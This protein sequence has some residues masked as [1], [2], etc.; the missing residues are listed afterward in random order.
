[1]PLM[2]VAEDLTKGIMIK[3]VGILFEP[4]T[5]A[6]QVVSLKGRKSP[7]RL[8]D[9]EGKI[10]AICGRTMVPNL[11]TLWALLDSKMKVRFGA[12][13]K[14]GY[15]TILDM[16]GESLLPLLDQA[17][18]DAAVLYW[19]YGYES[20]QRYETIC[21]PQWEFE[22][23][24]ARKNSVRTFGQVLV[25]PA[26]QLRQFS[27][28]IRT[29]LSAIQTSIDTS[30]HHGSFIAQ[31]MNVVG[32]ERR[33]FL[34]RYEEIRQPSVFLAPGEEHQVTRFLEEMVQ[35]GLQVGI[36]KDIN[37]SRLAHAV[38]RIEPSLETAKR[39]RIEAY[40]ETNFELVKESIAGII[41]ESLTSKSEEGATKGLLVYGP[42]G[43]G[44]THLFDSVVE[45]VRRQEPRLE[46]EELKEDITTARFTSA[47]KKI[48]QSGHPTLLLI[49]EVDG[50][51]ILRSRHSTRDDRLLNT[52]LR[53]MNEIHPSQARVFIYATTNYVDRVDEAVIHRERLQ[54]VFVFLPDEESRLDLLRQKLGSSVQDRILKDLARRTQGHSVSGLLTLVEL[55]RKNA[56]GHEISA[57]DFHHAL[58]RVPKVNSREI[59]RHMA[60]YEDYGS[61]L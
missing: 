49:D 41:I 42:S 53:E 11:L 22:R 26:G 60:K 4:K 32:E 50:D 1:M 30:L 58:E 40:G 35:V 16:P 8:K 24:H 57:D 56:R 47:L 2:Q 33:R 5:S 55:A 9:L 23:S 28:E 12:R 52:F 20:T 13:R 18:A 45:A 27:D 61:V 46:K 15:V 43:N 3:I 17:V 7:R 21:R 31:E 44:K 10:L 54:P 51:R 29:I 25:V 48:R 59:Q 19:P 38:H 36:I 37:K 14:L 39:T 34:S 6:V